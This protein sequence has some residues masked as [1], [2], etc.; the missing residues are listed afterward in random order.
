MARAPDQIS[1]RLLS[2]LGSDGPVG[3]PPPTEQLASGE[4]TALPALQGL[5]SECDSQKTC[6]L[7]LALMGKQ[8]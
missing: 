4:A 1:G 7:L 2:L 5:F 3:E 8:P 6:A